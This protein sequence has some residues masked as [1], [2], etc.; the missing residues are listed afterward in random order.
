MTW[1]A[2]EIAEL[3][4]LLRQ[5]TE[6]DVLQYDRRDVLVGIRANA[7]QAA[8]ISGLLR[9]APRLIAAAELLS[10]VQADAEL[11]A[12]MADAV[13]ENERLRVDRAHD[14]ERLAKAKAII[15]R[16]M[17]LPSVRYDDPFL[18]EEIEALRAEIDR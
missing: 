6:G 5:A 14:L 16:L 13:E 8:G 12:K 1:T 17:A 3:R 11:A 15:E 10:A 7:F 4:V 2:E 9:A 18:V